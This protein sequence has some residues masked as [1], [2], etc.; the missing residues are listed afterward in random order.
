MI[1]AIHFLISS[2][3]ED[4]SVGTVG[5]CSLLASIVN[6]ETKGDANPKSFFSNISHIKH[7][8]LLVFLA[9]DPGFKRWILLIA[10]ALLLSKALV[11]YPYRLRERVGMKL[12]FLV[13]LF[14]LGISPDGVH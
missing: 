14:I 7:C 3:P 9:N 10:L 4:I 11:D 1:Q 2:Y 12:T 6:D 5:S 8:A 13:E